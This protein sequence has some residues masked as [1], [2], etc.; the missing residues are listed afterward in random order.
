MHYLRQVFPFDVIAYI[1]YLVFLA[2]RTNIFI[3]L[4]FIAKIV[5]FMVINGQIEKRISIYLLT[6]S[7]FKF[8]RLIV[9]ILL[10][11]NFSACLFF[12]ID[13]DLYLQKGYEYQ[14]GFLWLTNSYITQGMDII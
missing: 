10:V 7:I 3:K 1:S 4:F 9:F 12:F 13:Y 14:N 8:L 2:I 11:T 5:S 6:S